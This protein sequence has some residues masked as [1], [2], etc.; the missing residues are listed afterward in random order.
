MSEQWTD[1]TIGA[2][3][4]IVGGGTPSTKEP[5]YWNGDVIWLTPTEVVKADGTSI[6]QSERTLTQAG[7][8]HS[9]AKLLPARTVLLTSRASVG[10]AALASV[11]LTTNQGFQSLI[12]KPMVLP[13]FLLLWIQGNRDE[14]RSR[15][16][17]ST[18]PEISKGKV[19]SVPIRYPSVPSQRRIVDLMTHLDGH[20]ANL[21]TER[22][23]LSGD[24]RRLR[25]IVMS[26]G[27]LR[28]AGDVFDI[29]MGRQRSPSRAE[30]PN[31]TRYL[32]AA[33]VKDGR[34]DL[35]DV[36]E[37]DFDAVERERFGLQQGDVLVSEGSGSA[38]AV[39]AAA[40]WN[41]ELPGT[42]CLQNTL[43]RYRAVPGVTTA[44]FVHHWCRWAYDSGAFRET[45]NGTNILHIGS[46][47][48]VEMPVGW[49]SLE[50][51]TRECSALD[52]YDSA[53]RALTEEVDALATVRRV[54]LDSLL[55]GE[56]PVK[57][58]Y[59]TLLGEAA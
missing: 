20:L 33:N 43:L 17:G 44:S 39:G 15:A 8:D 54:L 46:T 37:M 52:E 57:V 19:A 3:A 23:A 35:S 58:A 22:D 28:R 50:A 10:F 18:F 9:S 32:R 7:V 11:P 45:A 38:E 49:R 56:L 53:I 36:K 24:Q 12:A 34:L 42:V 59:D 51:Q 4:D 2:V 21:R 16:S 25:D 6:N 40:Q 41:G 55:T 47:R 14:F 26:R 27:E 31:M 29:L 48:A 13:E 1:A 5:S 30:G